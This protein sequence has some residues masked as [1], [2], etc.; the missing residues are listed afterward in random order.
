MENK[1]AIVTGG[2]KGIGEAIVKRLAKEDNDILIVDIQEEL[3]KEVLKELLKN[4]PKIRGEVFNIDVSDIN[5]V[6]DMVECIEKKYKKI[7]ILV[8]NAGIIKDNLVVRMT[9]ED[10]KKVLDI[11][12]M[13]AFNMTK[14]IAKLM[15]K[16]R[17]GKIINISSVIGIV[18]NIGQSNYAASK[19][20]LI[21]FTKSIAKELAPF[22]ITANCICPG[23]INTNMTKALKENI[24]KDIL[25]RIPLQRFGEPEEVAELVAFLVSDKANYITGQAIIIDGGL[26][27]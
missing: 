4:N 17:Y 24:K 19:A 13:G 20:A 25:G 7:D 2:A 1:V 12:F 27:M 10:M 11:N 22:K 9:Q 21:G 6:K 14:Y 26:F 15:M 23:F 18:G 16:R 8:N 3:A 5:Q